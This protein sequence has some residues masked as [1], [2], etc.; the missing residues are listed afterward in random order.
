MTLVDDLLTR[1]CLD[2]PAELLPVQGTCT[3]AYATR[4]HVIKIAHEAC[5]DQIYTE[6]LVAPLARAAGVRTPALV[7]WA[8]GPDVAYTIW[9]RVDGELLDDRRD[10][11]VWRAVGRELS[12]LHTIDRVVD[13]RGVLH[14][15]D[16]RDA[17]PYLHALPVA[18]ADLIARWLSRCE[19]AR[20]NAPRVTHYDVHGLNIIR[21][22]DGAPWLID[23]A[24][25]AWAD[26][27]ADF[28]SI[29]MHHV[30]DVL[31]GYEELASLG[32]RAE[33]R[34]LR[35]VI[36]QAVRKVATSD[37]SEPLEQL[38]AWLEAGPSR[39]FNDWLP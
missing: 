9:E 32:E 21:G 13:P 16:K 11:A 3:A 22:S 7:A 34:I 2:G 17:R 26:P 36:G 18:R 23:W 39:R 28:G 4:R 30:S 35:A 24:D 38:L 15:P 10:A 29:P 8:R 27:A 19:R 20:P 14:K 5:R 33:G 12:R 37:W 25:A 31:D 6:A 1:H